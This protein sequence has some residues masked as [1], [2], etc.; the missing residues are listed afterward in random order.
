MVIIRKK[1]IRLATL[2][3]SRSIFTFRF[4]TAKEETKETVSL[5]TSR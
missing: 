3:A 1:Q 4:A 2:C 5:P